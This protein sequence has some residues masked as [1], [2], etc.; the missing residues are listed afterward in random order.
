MNVIVTTG[1][2]LSSIDV[3]EMIEKEHDKLLR[4]IRRYS[5]QMSVA[6]IGESDFWIE[7]SYQNERGK[8]YPCYLVTKMGCEFIAHKMT[9]SK[10]T[11]FTAKYIS[12]FHEM[13]EQ[14]R[15]Q[16]LMPA[17][18]SEPHYLTT[19]T[20]CPAANLFYVTYHDEIERICKEKSMTKKQL[21]H[22]IM[23]ELSKSYDLVGATRIYRKETKRKPTYSSDIIGY[24]P[25]L[26]QAASVLLEEILNS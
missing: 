22:K 7:S 24:F 14:L 23:A 11:E 1:D 26:Y 16:S 19:T 15:K 13:E 20:K 6:K 21:F 12:R 9:G 8:T 5:N 3:A 18:H 4:D 17:V 2:K 10:G 25:E